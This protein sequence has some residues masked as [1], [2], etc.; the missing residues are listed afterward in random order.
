M[1]NHVSRTVRRTGF[2]LIELLVVIAIV[3]V[4]AA[5][6]FPVFG[7]VRERG[8][9]TACQGNLKQIA[10]AM[11]QYVQ[12][13]GGAYPVCV[14]YERQDCLAQWPNAIFS[15]VKDV[16]TFQCPDHPR[17]NAD[18]AERSVDQLPMADMDYLYDIAR[19]NVILPAPSSISNALG[20]H[21]SVLLAPTTT[22]L[23]M[24]TYWTDGDDVKHFFRE[25]TSSCGRR[26]KGNVLHS[27]GGNYSYLDGHVKWLTPEEAGEVECLNGPLPHPFTD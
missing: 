13:N 23:N 3:A 20:N 10:L 14:R 18:P 11:Q 15:Y 4:I 2:T 26:F 16:Q 19:L 24:E 8:R 7:A 25:V 6:L 22:W 27:G 1:Q 5:I 12:D 17:G 9:R 21:E